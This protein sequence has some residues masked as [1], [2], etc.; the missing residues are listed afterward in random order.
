M[1]Q[2]MGIMAKTIVIKSQMG[3]ENKIRKLWCHHCS[4]YHRAENSCCIY[5]PR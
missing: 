1:L 4:G 5:L 3:K 2:K